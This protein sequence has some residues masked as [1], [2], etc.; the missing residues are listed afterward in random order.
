MM[1]C[2]EVMTNYL[3]TDSY[4]NLSLRVRFHIYFCP[5]CKKETRL[6]TKNL[7]LIKN[8]P[9]FIMKSSVVDE[10]MKAIG[11]NQIQQESRT[12]SNFKWL[13]AWAIILAS[14]FMIPFNRQLA[15][16]RESFGGYFELPLVIV[17]GLAITLYSVI[18]I[19]THL[20]KIK[21]KVQLN[22]H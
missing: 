1:Q 16:L 8:T 22:N 12:V 9:P 3:K 18:Y 11:D 7:D 21:D 20:E 5:D 10:V 13:L 19:A 14:I 4:K 2:N 17:L 15:W 6:M